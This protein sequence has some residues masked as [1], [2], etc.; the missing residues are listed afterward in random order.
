MGLAAESSFYI[1]SH[2]NKLSTY[3]FLHNQ[4]LITFCL[5]LYL[6][7]IPCQA[8]WPVIR[9]P[10]HDNPRR[11]MIATKQSFPCSGQV[12]N[13][14]YQSKIGNPFRAIVWRPASNNGFEVVGFNS[15]PVSR[16]NTPITY[17]VPTS[18]RITVQKGDVI[19][20]AFTGPALSYSAGSGT[21]DTVLSLYGDLTHTHLSVGKVLYLN[22]GTPSLLRQYSLS[23]TLDETQSG[24][25]SQ[26]IIVLMK[27]S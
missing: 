11:T 18:Q 1:S 22:H 27:F 26:I 13:W 7:E 17:V 4:R 8:G 14:R 24:N 20:W 15:I 23:A 12:T 3:V 5:P 9:R 21:N 10:S 2:R 6:A 16:S 25:M 19:G